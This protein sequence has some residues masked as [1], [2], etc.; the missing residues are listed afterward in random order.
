MKRFLSLLLTLV[1]ILSMF[2]LI[3]TTA[4]A[5]KF[6][7]WEYEINEDETTVTITKC[8]GNATYTG[9]TIPLTIEGKDVTSIDDSAFNNCT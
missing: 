3:G 4:F 1:V 5:Y 7:I 6:G 8:N 9:I 2:S